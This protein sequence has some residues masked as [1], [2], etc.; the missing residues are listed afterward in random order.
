MR[1]HAGR[2]DVDTFEGCFRVYPVLPAGRQVYGIPSIP[3][4]HVTQSMACLSSC[5]SCLPN[6]TDW[7]VGIY[8]FPWMERIAYHCAC[9]VLHPHWSASP[10]DLRC[11]RRLPSF[12]EE[13]LQRIVNQ[14]NPPPFGWNELDSMPVQPGGKKANWKT[15]KV[16]RGLLHVS[17]GT[18]RMD[19]G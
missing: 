18:K 16:V 5:P 14:E 15:H 9:P 8:P 4:F 13:A 1:D 17:W 3:S 10:P 7:N 19:T 6:G 12:H 2:L 11:H